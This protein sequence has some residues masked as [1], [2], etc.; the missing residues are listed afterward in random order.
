MVEFVLCLLGCWPYL[1]LVGFLSCAL[2]I[3]SGRTICCVA[4][5]VTGL[6]EG[7]GDGA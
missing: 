3:E 4:K 5:Y 7:V 1:L 2:I 6:G